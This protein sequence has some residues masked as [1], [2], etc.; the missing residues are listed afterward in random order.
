MAI[1]RHTLPRRRMYPTTLITPSTTMTLVRHAGH[2][3]LACTA[4]PPRQNSHAGSARSRCSRAVPRPWPGQK[5]QRTRTN[6]RERMNRMRRTAMRE[7]ERDKAEGEGGKQNTNKSCA[8]RRKAHHVPATVRRPI[9]YDRLCVDPRSTL[10]T[11]VCRQYLSMCPP[12]L[13]VVLQW[14]NCRGC[15]GIL[16]CYPRHPRHHRN[17]PPNHDNHSS[18]TFQ[19]RPRPL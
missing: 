5:R 8:T 13:L 19:P 10:R 16:L 18:P 11:H 1:W 9:K 7:G 12:P 14:N 2:A 3:D 6:E 15:S 17:A 4:T